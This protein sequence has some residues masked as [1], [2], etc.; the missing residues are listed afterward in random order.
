MKWNRLKYPLSTHA[1]LPP[2]FFEAVQIPTPCSIEWMASA[3][4]ID[5]VGPSGA[6]RPLRHA[7]AGRPRAIP[8]DFHSQ[9]LL[10]MVSALVLLRWH[11]SRWHTYT[12]KEKGYECITSGQRL[13]KYALY[14]REFT[15]ALAAKPSVMV[16][17]DSPQHSVCKVQ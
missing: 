10:E 16:N 1:S 9:F 12:A 7:L 5:P 3:N 8:K 17:G 13:T 2:F 4:S 6:R 15:M 14:C 11:V